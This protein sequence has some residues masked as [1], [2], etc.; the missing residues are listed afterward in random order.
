MP[1]DMTQSPPSSLRIFI[2]DDNSN[3]RSLYSRWIRRTTPRSL[4]I[5]EM[6]TGEEGL[7]A[8]KHSLPH[9]MLLDCQLPDMTGL[10]FLKKVRHIHSSSNTPIIFLTEQGNEQVA[11]QAI[12]L[13]AHTFLI[14]STLSEEFL[15]HHIE[16]AIAQSVTV[17]RLQAL[18]RQSRTILQSS[19][20]GL[21]VVDADGL[22]RFSNPAAEH[23]L[24]KTT[25]ELLGSPFGYSIFQEEI[26]EIVIHHPDGPTT[27]VEMRVVPIEWDNESA[28]LISLRDLT[29]RRKA[30]EDQKRHELERQYA[31]KLESL[32][33]LAGGIAHDF[34]NLLMTVVARAGL[35]LRSLP[36]DDPAREHLRFIEKAGLRGGELA[37]QMLTFAG[38]TQLNFQSVDCSL[39]L[40]EMKSIIRSAVSKKIAVNM[41]TAANLPHIRGDR[42]QLRQ[43]VMNI[44]INAAEAIGDGGG[45]ITI[46]TEAMDSST[47]D[48]RPFHIIGDLPWGP[49]VS[50]RISDTGSGI[51]PEL[52]PKIFDPFFTTKFPGRGLGLAAILGIIRAHGGALAVQSQEGKGTEF[53]FLFPFSQKTP[54]PP[55]STRLTI[56]QAPPVSS[57]SP[58]MILIVDD[59][60]D[61]LEACSLILR[62]IGMETLVA[63]DGP[64]GLQLFKQYE[65]HLA[66]VLV[67]LTMPHMDGGMLC[68]EIRLLN[69]HVPLLVS[70]GYTEQEAMKHFAGLEIVSFI[71]KP[72]QVEVL[73]EKVQQLTRAMPSPPAM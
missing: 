37:N 60:K 51:K 45:V 71:Q 2:I 69:A 58:K 32:G 52:I 26:R 1:I 29:E 41:E 6:E 39:L 8:C 20:D 14:K 48:L 59:E 30:E 12:K 65:R 55:R 50:V 31:Q 33:V 70:S 4:E 67:D 25:E 28:A 18:E 38:Q 56:P 63:S 57:H 61:V 72:F 44:T 43:M 36:K 27:P 16:Q 9:C 66:F 3:N 54:T 68:K 24:R 53:W 21:M 42:A 73:I 46:T 34:N 22:C 62:E 47:K 17:R 11:A 13:G 15:W 35:A 49:C 5:Q 23:L 19:R 40:K 64:S 10:N 7:E